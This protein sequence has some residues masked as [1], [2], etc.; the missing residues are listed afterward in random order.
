MLTAVKERDATD[1]EEIARREPYFSILTNE[2]SLDVAG[3][4]GASAAFFDTGEGDITTLLAAISSLLGR[5]LRLGRVLDFG[6]GVGRL[7]LPLA[8]RAA[9][10]VA[11]DIAPTM[12]VHAR[13]NALEAGL[14]NVSFLSSA[15]LDELAPGEFDF[16]CSLLV[17]EHIPPSVG[18]GL[19]QALTKLLAPGG[20][21]AIQ[22]KDRQAD[23]YDERRVLGAIEP[24]GARVVAKLPTHQGGGESSAIVVM[25][26]RATNAGEMPDAR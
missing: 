3:N 26:K 11:C 23:G 22:L 12:L 13:R 24:A 10:V 4:A 5:D 21:G 2:G 7:T 20:V 9:H 6:C 8:R 1:W 16:I 18:Y 17:F 14:R 15:E 19:L 25:V